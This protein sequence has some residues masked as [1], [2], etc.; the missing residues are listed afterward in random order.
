MTN[1]TV[2]APGPSLRRLREEH[3]F[4]DGPIVA[5]NLAVLAPLRADFWCVLDHPLKMA[6]VYE[7]LPCHDRKRLPVLWC[8]EAEVVHWHDR[9]VRCMPFASL[10]HDF[11]AQNL[12]MWRGKA[13]C[14]LL[15]RTITATISRC[16]GL[17]ASHVDVFGC[18]MAGHQHAF[19]ADP[20][21]RASSA[22]DQR[23][24]DEP[25]VFK[26]AQSMWSKHATVALRQPPS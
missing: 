15:G 10:E 17:G 18:D 25:E 24:K 16:I 3:V 26:A 22:W 4:A 20:D 21:N 9:H 5:I 11:V 2:L 7:R 1:W 14:S 8:R 12:P 23:W 19:G 6:Q 13:P